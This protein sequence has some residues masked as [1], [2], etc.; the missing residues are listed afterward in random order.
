MNEEEAA[1]AFQ[2][3]VNSLEDGSLEDYYRTLLRLR[4]DLNTMLSCAK[5]DGVD[6]EGL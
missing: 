2:K 3:L 4:V 1:E 6:L 5:G